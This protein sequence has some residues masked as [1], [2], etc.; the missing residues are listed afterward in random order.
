[1]FVVVDSGIPRQQCLPRRDG[2]FAVFTDTRVMLG[3][4]TMVTLDGTPY[5]QPDEAASWPVV[6]EVACVWDW[7]EREGLV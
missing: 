2:S 5:H 7:Q 3:G 4:L 6:G 1:M